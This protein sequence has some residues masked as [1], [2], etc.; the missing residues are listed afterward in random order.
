[1]RASIARF[2]IQRSIVANHGILDVILD[3]IPDV[4]PDVIF[5][6]ARVIPT[7]QR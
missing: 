4:I 2:S 7:S 5:A 3:V 1:V 6:A